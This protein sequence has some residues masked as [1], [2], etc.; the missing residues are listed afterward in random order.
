[1]WCLN[2]VPSFL[3]LGS[4]GSL[5]AEESDE[6][7]TLALATAVGAEGLLAD[8]H[9]ALTVLDAAGLEELDGP[10][11]VGGD[12][13]DL[14]DHLSDELGALAADTLTV[15]GLDLLG[16]LFGELELGDGVSFA[17]ADGDDGTCCL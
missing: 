17:E 6:V 1:M 16:L 3:G 15:G 2:R 14:V 10:L 4:G 13:A 9:G 12:T 7:F 11:L 5:G 8:L